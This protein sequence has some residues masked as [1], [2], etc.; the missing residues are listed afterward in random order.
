MKTGHVLVALDGSPESRAALA[1]AIFL[2]RLAGG[3]LHLLHVVDAGR[4]VGGT[5]AK[6][7]T[8]FEI[9]TIDEIGDKLAAAFKSEGREILDEAEKAAREAGLPVD[10]L[11]EVGRPAGWILSH[12]RDADLLAL[13]KRGRNEAP[14]GELGH[15]VEK[16]LRRL[17]AP[18]LVTGA[19]FPERIEKPVLA[20]DGRA[21]SHG[22]LDPALDLAHLLGVPLTIVKVPGYHPRERWNHVRRHVEEHRA[23]VRWVELED[24]PEE[25]PHDEAIL[26]AVHRHGHDLLIVGS[27]GYRA[28]EC[29]VGV[30]PVEKMIAGTDLPVLVLY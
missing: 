13:G 22:A 10:R 3:V 23:E 15:V 27:W 5:L 29:A 18:V 11:I 20:Y 12:G 14:R 2:A 6:L 8:F 4:L 25:G 28:E 7:P 16:V 21:A 24:L 26:E 19:S 1:G 17:P 9:G 30:S